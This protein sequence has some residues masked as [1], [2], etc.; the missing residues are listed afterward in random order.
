MPRTIFLTRQSV[1]AKG[2]IKHK[3]IEAGSYIPER[4]GPILL[5]T[6]ELDTVLTT[7]KGAEIIINASDYDAQVYGPILKRNPGR[8]NEELCRAAPSQAEGDSAKSEGETGAGE[9]DKQEASNKG[10]EEPAP[11]ETEDADAK[12][13]K[14]GRGKQK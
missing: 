11:E 9:P 2:K 5:R 6:E 10:S 8:P 14:A 12:T 3:S 1:D 7:I 4:D 13:G